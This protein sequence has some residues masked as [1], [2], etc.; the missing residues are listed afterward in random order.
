EA[1]YEI[2]ADLHINIR[3][4]SP[5]QSLAQFGDSRPKQSFALGRIWDF[6]G[7][8]PVNVR[9]PLV[10]RDSPD[11]RH[12]QALRPLPRVKRPLV[13]TPLAK[14][15]RQGMQREC[16]SGRKPQRRVAVLDR[17]GILLESRPGRCPTCESKR[18][19]GKIWVLARELDDVT[20]SGDAD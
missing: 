9:G 10:I 3:L 17:A 20:C 4:W 16:I 18:R 7:L 11:H 1:C 19:C 12:N 5:R 14:D 13:L 15:L 2:R 8:L 6:G